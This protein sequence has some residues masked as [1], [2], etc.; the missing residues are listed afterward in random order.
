MAIGTVADL[1]ASMSLE[2]T[3]LPFLATYLTMAPDCTSFRPSMRRRGTCPNN[4]SENTK[5]SNYTDK[6]FSSHTYADKTLS[7]IKA[8]YTIMN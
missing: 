3:S 6:S 4:K 5:F 8:A 2:P 1:A 7:V